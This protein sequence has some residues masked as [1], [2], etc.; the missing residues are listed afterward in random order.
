MQAADEIFRIHR[1]NVDTTKLDTKRLKK[2][3]PDIYEEFSRTIRSRRFM[4]SAA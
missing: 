4:V 2:M 1:S 3:R